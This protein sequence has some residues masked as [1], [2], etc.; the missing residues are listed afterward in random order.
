[1]KQNTF[2]ALLFLL[3]G[4]KGIA[5]TSSEP[6]S[7]SF[8][9]W[10]SNINKYE[11]S[12]EWYLSSEL[13]FRRTQGLK[14]WRQFLTRPALNYAWSEKTHFAVGYSFIQNYPPIEGTDAHPYEHNVWEQVTL[15][16]EREKLSTSHRY[17]LEHRWVHTP[18]VGDEGNTVHELERRE[19]FRYRLTAEVPL[20]KNE[21][22]SFEAFDEV[23]LN[24]F[25]P[26]RSISL[27]QN[28][29][30]GGLAY[31]FM[32][33]GKFGV[34]YMNMWAPQGSAHIIQTTL[35]FHVK[36]G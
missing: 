6:I 36:S 26:S 9:T 4:A 2:I 5:Q 16:N 20:T 14:Q 8:D 19:R 22:L 23:W 34:G 11:L 25:D 1:M 29:I 17:R 7:P 27:D 31:R 13:H 10:W 12:K 33:R 30:Y 18:R 3:I 28:W 32:E 21:K 35:S 24:L 15:N